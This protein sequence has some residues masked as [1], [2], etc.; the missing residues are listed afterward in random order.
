MTTSQSGDWPA[1]LEALQSLDKPAY[2][3]RLERE[4]DSARRTI[5]AQHQ[6]C[7]ELRAQ[8]EDLWFQVAELS[9]RAACVDKLKTVLKG[10][11]EHRGRIRGRGDPLFPC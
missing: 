2:I 7:Q 3:E 6:E 10:L 4:L 9:E 1:R 11:R 5:A 8:V